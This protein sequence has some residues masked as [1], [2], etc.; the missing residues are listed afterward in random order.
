[1][2]I[3]PAWMAMAFYVAPQ[4]F[5]PDSQYAFVEIT[6]NNFTERPQGMQIRDNTPPPYRVGIAPETIKKIASVNIKTSSTTYAY[7]IRT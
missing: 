2:E 3:T 1:M 5:Q 7:N 4:S 6:C